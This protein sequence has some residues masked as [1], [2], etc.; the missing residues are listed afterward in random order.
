MIQIFYWNEIDNQNLQ[1]CPC[2]FSNTII[3]HCIGKHHWLNAVHIY[4]KVPF[5]FNGKNQNRF[6]YVVKCVFDKHV[7]RIIVIPVKTERSYF[8]TDLIQIEKYYFS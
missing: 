7:I 5:L 6:F 3:V 8:K 2:R 1:K 4:M